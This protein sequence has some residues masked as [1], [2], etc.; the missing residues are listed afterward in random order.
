MTILNQRGYEKQSLTLFFTYLDQLGWL[1]S[2]TEFSDGSD[3]RN[4]IDTY[5]L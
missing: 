3:F 4:W 2:S 1:T 5:L